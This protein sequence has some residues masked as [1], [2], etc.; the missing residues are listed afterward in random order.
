MKISCVIVIMLIMTLM[1]LDTSLAFNCGRQAGGVRCPTGMCC[2]QWGWCGTTPAHCGR[3]RCQSQCKL[4]LPDE[5]ANNDKSPTERV[6]SV[7]AP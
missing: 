3:G 2:S 4:D 6:A 5:Q 7:G 1:M